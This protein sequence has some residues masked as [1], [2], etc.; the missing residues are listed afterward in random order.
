MRAEGD[1]EEKPTEAR[2]D[3]WR[4]MAESGRVRPSRPSRCLPG[5]LCPLGAFGS[6]QDNTEEAL[7]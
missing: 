1:Q 4:C 2:A 7:R 6:K 3:I 5:S